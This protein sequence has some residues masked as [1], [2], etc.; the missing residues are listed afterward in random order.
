M[1]P[2][3]GGP[4]CL[5]GEGG[6]TTWDKVAYTIAVMTNEQ[7][8]MEYGVETIEAVAGAGHEALHGPT[9]R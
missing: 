9:G 7:P 5:H 4:L 3:W 8:S 1:L 6:R 2:D